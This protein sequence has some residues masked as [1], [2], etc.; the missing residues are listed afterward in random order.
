MAHGSEEAKPA[1]M[2]SAPAHSCHTWRLSSNCA[3]P[4]KQSEERSIS[5]PSVAST[6]QPEETVCERAA[7]SSRPAQMPPQ[8]A[9][10]MT[11]LVWTGTPP[12]WSANAGGVGGRGECAGQ[13][14]TG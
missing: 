13:R 2:M 8:K 14:A 5:E 6:G 1:A 3:K 12:T 10:E 4:M 7:H 9:D 11:A